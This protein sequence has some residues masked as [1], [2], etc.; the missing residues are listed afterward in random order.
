MSCVFACSDGKKKAAPPA[1]AAA[2][3]RP[4]DAAPAPADPTYPSNAAGLQTLIKELL[5]ARAAG[6]SDRTYILT[7]SLRLRDYEA[8]FARIF[9]DELG[10]KLAADY[11]IQ[12]DD[13]ELLADTLAALSEQGRSEIAIE[14]F[15]SVQDLKAVG[16]QIAALKAMKSPVTLFSVRMQTSDGK[17]PFHIWSF[18]HDG[19]SFRYAGKMKPVARPEASDL[20]DLGEFRVADA[21]RLRSAGESGK[22]AGL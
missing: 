5:A 12:F 8:W 11:K 20:G 6:D 21:N 7:E 19:K 9:G 1:D 4:I 14:R 16:Y 3:P 15:E 17:K 22:D 2:A 18:I 10:P 13:I